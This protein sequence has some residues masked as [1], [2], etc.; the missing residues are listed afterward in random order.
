MQKRDPLAKA[1]TKKAG[2]DGL[3]IMDA[4]EFRM[5]AGKGISAVIGVT[6]YYFGNERYIR[7]AGIGIDARPAAALESFRD[8]GKTAVLIADSRSVISMIALSDTI[9]PEAA[10][11]IRSLSSMNTKAVLLT[12]DNEKSAG[13]L[14]SLAGIQEVHAD[15]LPEQKVKMIETLKQ[16]G[17]VCMIGTASMTHRL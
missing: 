13:H 7:A 16:S 5:E 17:T 12:G 6:Q 2:R 11:V 9:R 4:E 14:A 1:I 10:A 8:E 15:L 3:N